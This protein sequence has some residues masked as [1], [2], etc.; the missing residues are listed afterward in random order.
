[1]NQ[2]SPVVITLA[3]LDTLIS[4]LRADGFRVIG[5]RL[6]DSAIIYD[7]VETVRDLPAGWTDE[8][9]GGHYRVRR[10]E[11]AALFGYNVGPTAWKRFLHPPMRI[12]RHRHSG[13]RVPA[14]AVCRYAL[15][16]TS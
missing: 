6:R 12:A 4:H 13:S 8:Q 15:P 14:R 1:M 10:R 9:E 11:D 7:D 3:G 2:H 16:R 5:P